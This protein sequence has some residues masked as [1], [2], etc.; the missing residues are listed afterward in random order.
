MAEGVG[1]A[2]QDHAEP[3]R[4]P[5]QR[6]QGPATAIRIDRDLGVE[7]DP[8][9]AH[10]PVR[11]IDPAEVGI[12]TQEE[13]FRPDPARGAEAQIGIAVPGHRLRGREGERQRQQES[14]KL[15]GEI[16]QPMAHPHVLSLGFPPTG[17]KARQ[18][19]A[20]PTSPAPPGP[21]SRVAGREQDRRCRSRAVRRR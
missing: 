15:T 11:D 17:I 3:A 2:Q 9:E 21:S 8:L 12:K 13:L 19:V 4:R 6:N 20:L 18:R 10:L 14:Q 1:I 16:A 5:R 7:I